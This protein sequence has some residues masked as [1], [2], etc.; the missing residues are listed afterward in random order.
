MGQSSSWEANR[1]VASQE[2]PPILWNTKVHYRIQK[3]PPPVS[4]LSQP[5]PVHTPT[6]HFL[7]IQAP[8]IPGTKSHVPLSLLRSYYS[9]SPGPRLCLWMFR[10][11]DSF[12]QWGGVVSP[13]PIPKLKN[14]PFSAV[15]DCLFNIFAAT[16]H[17]G[18]RSSI[19]NLRTRHAVV[20]ATHFQ[21]FALRH[22]LTVVPLD[23]QMCVWQGRFQTFLD[24]NA[25][26]TYNFGGRTNAWSWTNSAH[27][28]G[29][30]NHPSAVDPFAI[31]NPFS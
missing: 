26:Y 15:R 19:R 12:S 2:I 21:R 17:T 9:I 5:N 14:H 13:R 24:H 31:R 27:T 20:T 30:L 8:K 28:V 3:C 7:K 18:S 29:I 1:S 4:I 25:K 16:L 11:K 6:S 22:P 10:N 23:K